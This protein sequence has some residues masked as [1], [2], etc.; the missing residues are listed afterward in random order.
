[1]ADAQSC[2]PNNDESQW[3]GRRDALVRCVAASIFGPSAAATST[4]AAARTEICMLFDEDGSMMRMESPPLGVDLDGTIP[5]E[6]NIISTWRSAAINAE[7]QV[8]TTATA[9]TNAFGVGVIKN[10]GKGGTSNIGTTC[11]K[12]PWKYANERGSD[13]N[14]SESATPPEATGPSD[15]DVSFDLSTL[16]SKRDVLMHIQKC[17]PLD[18]LRKHRLNSSAEVI[19]RKTNRTKLTRN[20]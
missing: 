2:R 15:S 5:T 3:W 1:M 20:S 4:T 16:S 12:Q 18:F 10:S 14:G 13:K 8:Q 6:R 9:T 7:R 17:C 19:L 11:M